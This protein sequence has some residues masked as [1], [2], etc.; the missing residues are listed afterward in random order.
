MYHIE[1]SVVTYHGIL[2]ILCGVEAMGIWVSGID[3]RIVLRTPEPSVPEPRAT[4]TN[5]SPK[6]QKVQVYLF[7]VH[8]IATTY[9]SGIVPDNTTRHHN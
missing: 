2:S 8:D 5:R 4:V 3:A 1:I 7:K 6:N 9:R